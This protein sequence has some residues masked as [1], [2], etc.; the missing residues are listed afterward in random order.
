MSDD[1][2]DMPSTMPNKVNNRSEVKSTSEIIGKFFAN[3]FGFTKNIPAVGIQPGEE[4]RKRGLGDKDYISYNMPWILYFYPDPKS[5]PNYVLLDPEKDKALLNKIKG[6]VLGLIIFMIFVGIIY[7]CW[8]SG[9]LFPALHTS[10]FFM[11]R[12]IT[13]TVFFLAFMIIIAIFKA[14]PFIVSNIKYYGELTINPYKDRTA[15]RI[16]HKYSLNFRWFFYGGYTI[17]FFLASVLWTLLLVLVIIPLIAIF[18][19]LCGLVLGDLNTK[20]FA[21]G[22]AEYEVTELQKKP[23]QDRMANAVGIT[24]A[25]EGLSSGLSYLEGKTGIGK[26]LAR[27]LTKGLSTGLPSGLTKG[28]SE[29]KSKMPSTANPFLKYDSDKGM[30]QINAK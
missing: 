26:G 9:G 19:T 15:Y 10:W 8:K 24:K 6:Q 23:M 14:V 18:G 13:L 22:M 3:I 28:L 2:Q 27:G 29:I 17:A 20:Y 25:K 4:K 12:Y 11:W 16:C 30:N 7:V 21:F 5:D 1:T